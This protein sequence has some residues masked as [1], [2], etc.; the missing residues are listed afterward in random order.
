[1]RRGREGEAGATGAVSCLVLLRRNQPFDFFSGVRS[2]SFVD[3][4]DPLGNGKALGGT[5]EG[6]TEGVVSCVLFSAVD[7]VAVDPVVCGR[8]VLGEVGSGGII[9]PWASTAP[10]R[11]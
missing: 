9:A 7:T 5:G 11:R 6:G 8:R 3:V 1:M 4:W 10:L 2:L